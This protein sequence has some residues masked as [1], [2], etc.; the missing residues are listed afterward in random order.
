MSTIRKQLA[1]TLRQR[2]QDISKLRVVAGF[3][4][5]VDQLVQIVEERTDLEHFTP[6]PT[7]SRFAEL[8]AA[9]AGKSSL[10]EFVVHGLD[11]GG[12]AVN[13]GD[14]IATLGAR[15]DYF[16]TLGEPRHPA[17]DAFATKCHSCTSWGREPGFT[18]AVEFQDGKTMFSSVSQLAEFNEAHLAGCLENGGFLAAC[19]EAS[20]IA[21]TNWTLYPHMSACWSLLQRQVFS[22]LEHRP[23]VFIDLVDP[24]GRSQADLRALLPVLTDFEK[25][26][27]CVLG[28]NLNEANVFASLLGLKPVN[29]EGQ[30]VAALCE[31]IRQALNLHEVAIH[32]VTGA[33]VSAGDGT[34]W[35]DGPHTPSPK[36]STGAGDRYNAGYCLG[37][38]LDLSP[39][40]RCLLG[41]AS[42]GFFVRNARSGTLGE[43]ANLL[44]DWEAGVLA[45]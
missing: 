22:C 14:G 37:R 41:T 15:L 19:V 10:R 23:W 31:E 9:S 33:A 40:E 6:V 36:K 5:F 27:R 24:R 11:A 20:L 44:E 7:I 18:M 17:F 30:A 39:A 4:G 42:S 25:H 8:L 32:C 1:D 2:S 12:C 34:V 29:E 35:V 45:P 3:D 26:T 43:I 38:M 21:L 16:G 13:L 28:G